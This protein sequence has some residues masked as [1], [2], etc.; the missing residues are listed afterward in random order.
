M[1]RRGRQTLAF[2]VLLVVAGAFVAPVGADEAKSKMK[3][4]AKDF[5]VWPATDLKWEALPDAPPGPMLATISGDPTK[6]G[7]TA[8]EKFPAGFSAAL[9]SHSTD[10]KVV[11]I[12]GTWIH[13]EEGKPEVRLG[14]GSYLFQPANK[15]HTTACDAAAECIFFIDSAGK[16]DIKMAEEKKAP[17]K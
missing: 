2:S 10:H 11:I 3:G 8:I 4:A 14:P 12:S 7:Y 15:K 1:S 5:V 16:F 9:H 6:G 13:S 17:A